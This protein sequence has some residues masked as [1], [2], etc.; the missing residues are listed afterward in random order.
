MKF[1]NPI[2][3]EIVESLAGVFLGTFLG[4][5]IAHFVQERINKHV[6]ENCPIHR[7]VVFKT[8]ITSN[9]AYHCLK[10]EY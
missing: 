3:R 8:L 7:I 9:G 1:Q 5:V 10:T 2:D 6:L 4:F